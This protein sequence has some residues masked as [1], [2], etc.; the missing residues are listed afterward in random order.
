[1]LFWQQIRVHSSHLLEHVSMV[2]CRCFDHRLL[3]RDAACRHLQA[4]CQAPSSSSLLGGS[5]TLLL[6]LPQPDPVQDRQLLTT[7]SRQCHLQ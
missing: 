6:T 2:Y 1:M 7:V 5:G 4:H 3:C